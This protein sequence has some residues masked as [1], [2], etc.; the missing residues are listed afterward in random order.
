METT[1]KIHEAIA[2]I[3]D[4]VGGVGKT[5][6]NPQ[7]GYKYRGIA[8]VTLA[9][10]PIMA[11][12]KVHATPHAILNE[13]A[14]YIDTKSGSKM[15]HVRQT[16]EYRFYHA[17]GSFFPCVVTGEAMDSG[18]KTSNKVMSAAL[19]YALTQTFCIPE[20]DPDADTEAQSPQ[21]T[22]APQP[23]TAKPPAAPAPAGQPAR[24]P[25]V[26]NPDD[27][28][29]GPQSKA[30]HAL[31]TKV[32]ISDDLERMEHVSRIAGI[33]PTITSV[34]SLTKGEASTVIEALGKELEV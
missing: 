18:D 29:T 27:P 9:C 25:Q 24:K 19:K 30:I 21:R 12:H 8:D 28:I 1:G 26:S 13:C 11:K 17:D 34:A 22:G 16:I 14:D 5:R 31:L 3:M 32:G 20:T 7:Q 2:A 33:T 23:E 15:L 4:E 6:T 10:Q